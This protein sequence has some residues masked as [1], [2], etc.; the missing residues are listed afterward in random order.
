MSLLSK[1]ETM[2]IQIFHINGLLKTYESLTTLHSGC[3]YFD[4]NGLRITTTLIDDL[5]FIL[6][7]LNREGHKGES[8]IM[9]S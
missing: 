4:V 6:V 2:S 5:G 3:L 1:I 7:G 9:A 8:F